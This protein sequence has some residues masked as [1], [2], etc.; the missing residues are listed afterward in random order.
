MTCRIDGVKYRDKSSFLDSNYIASHPISGRTYFR[1]KCLKRE[2]R[3]GLNKKS[4]C[5]RYSIICSQNE[6]KTR[7]TSDPFS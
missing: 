5:S 7:L 6:D 2:L 1:V 4:Q 3:T